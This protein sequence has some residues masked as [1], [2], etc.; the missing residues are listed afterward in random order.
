VIPHSNNLPNPLN[1]LH[2]DAQKVGQI[3][4]LNPL[5]LFPRSNQILLG[6]LA[7]DHI[8]ERE[9]ERERERRECGERAANLFFVLFGE[10][11][12]HALSY[13]NMFILSREF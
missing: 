3:R 7:K 10:F 6:N 13:I 9:R 12:L 2:S 8:S 4:V 5:I 11:Q 1:V